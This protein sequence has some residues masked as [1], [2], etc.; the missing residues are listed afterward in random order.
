MGVRLAVLRGVVIMERRKPIEYP[1]AIRFLRRAKVKYPM[2]R[3][4]GSSALNVTNFSSIFSRKIFSY[5]LWTLL[6]LFWPLKI[7]SYSWWFFFTEHFKNAKEFR[8]AKNEFTK[9]FF[10][11]ITGPDCRNDL[12]FF[13]FSGGLFGIIQAS[14][15]PRQQ[16]P[17]FD[18]GT[19]STALCQTVK[20]SA[21]DL[22]T[23][24]EHVQPGHGEIENRYH[25][26]ISI[27]C[28]SL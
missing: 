1:K 3:T 5:F 18:E 14:L 9:V 26:S 22:S 21:P 24:I 6:T 8:R 15:S 23:F 28:R 16:I 4:K 7:L 19:F 2:R 11:E 20:L 10:L 13:P 17:K 27:R 12:L 25:R